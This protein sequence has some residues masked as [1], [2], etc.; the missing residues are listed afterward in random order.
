MTAYRILDEPSPTPMAR[1]SVNPFWVLLGIMLGG[2][3]LGWPWFVF[4]AYA[5][6]SATRVK[7]AVL[8]GVGLVGS[9]ALA[10]LGLALVSYGII[11]STA[12]PYA[13]TVLIV[14]KLGIAYAVHTC[15]AT[16]FEL[17]EYFGGSA[18][19]GLLVALGAM[20]LRPVVLRLVDAPF[21]AMV[22]A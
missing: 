21:W 2:A 11:D 22:L 16:S 6:G 15:Q 17:Y 18:K 4:N 5:I 8:C 14:W 13:A 9:A 19:S 10:A 3:W 7:E 1:L 12:L 20:L